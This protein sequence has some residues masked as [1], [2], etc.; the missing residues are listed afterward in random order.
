MSGARYIHGL[1]V[2]GV[3]LCW[4][5]SQGDRRTSQ[6]HREMTEDATSLPATGGRVELLDADHQEGLRLA[7]TGLR[8][9]SP[10]ADSPSDIQVFGDGSVNAGIGTLLRPIATASSA[11]SIPASSIPLRR[12]SATR[13][14][15][16][17]WRARRS[18]RINRLH[19]AGHRRRLD[20]AGVAARRSDRRRA[21]ER[22]LRGRRNRYGDRSRRQTVSTLRTSLLST[23]ADPVP[24]DPGACAHRPT[25]PRRVAEDRDHGR[26]RR[27]RAAGSR[28]DD[29]R[30]ARAGP[31]M[32]P[33]KLTLN[34]ERGTRSPSRSASFAI[35]CSRRSWPTWPS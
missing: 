35:S 33:V 18:S 32:I 27:H 8:V 11:A 21:H 29:R 24:D 1:L 2:G 34:S 22:R 15:R 20:V 3:G 12:P 13:A 28:H 6:P 30:H 9:D 26:R 23:R 5:S 16:R 10:L 7:P 4:V 19:R 31:S 14:S 17:S 25:Q